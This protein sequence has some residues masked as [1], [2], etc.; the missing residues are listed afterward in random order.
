[1][2][3]IAIYVVLMVRAS[4]R[5]TRERNDCKILGMITMY[6]ALIVRAS[7]RFAREPDDYS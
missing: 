4:T 2:C 7:V 3:M 1:M 5:I 6:I